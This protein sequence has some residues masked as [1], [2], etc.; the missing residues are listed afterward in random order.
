MTVGAIAASATDQQT[1]DTDIQIRCE[2]CFDWTQGATN[3]RYLECD[4]G[5]Q[6]TVSVMTVDVQR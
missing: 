5:T 3:D 2:N 4:R 1:M 6:Y